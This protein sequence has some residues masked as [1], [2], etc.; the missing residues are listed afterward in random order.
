MRAIFRMAM[1]ASLAIILIGICFASHAF[2]Q[3]ADFGAWNQGAVQRLSWQGAPQLDSSSLFLVAN[4]G[5]DDRIAGFWKRSF[6]QRAMPIYPMV[7]WSIVHSCSGIAMVP[8]L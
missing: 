1:T 6:W 2:A 3:C 5:H 4:Q 8:K 7:R